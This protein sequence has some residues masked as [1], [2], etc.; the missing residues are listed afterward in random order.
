MRSRFGLP[1]TAGMLALAF[2]LVSPL[3]A[4]ATTFTPDISSALAGVSSN[5]STMATAVA[6]IAGSIAGILV[7][8][9]LIK[10]FIHRV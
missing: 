1:F 2:L 7:I 10:R 9:R 8:I 5:A 4:L 6:V 3:D